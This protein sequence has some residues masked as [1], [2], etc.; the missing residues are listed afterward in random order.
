[1]FQGFQIELKAC[2]FPSGIVSDRFKHTLVV[3]KGWIDN[4]EMKKKRSTLFLNMNYEICTYLNGL[5]FIFFRL[6][7][8]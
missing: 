2:N 1:M 4:T 3:L 8:L 5:H 6:L 7:N